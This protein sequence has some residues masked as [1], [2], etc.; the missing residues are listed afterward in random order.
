ML[1]EEVLF[2]TKFLV[3]V[4]ALSGLVSCTDKTANTDP[5]D[6]FK[7]SFASQ[8]KEKVTKAGFWSSWSRDVVKQQVVVSV[9]DGVYHEYK[10]T[11]EDGDDYEL[12][13]RVFRYT[14][15]QDG[16]YE[17][18]LVADECGEIARTA[19]E[20]KKKAQTFKP[21]VDQSS[22][23]TVSGDVVK[24]VSDEEHRKLVADI[25]KNKALDKYDYG[26]NGTVRTMTNWWNK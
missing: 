20:Q 11:S 8:K 22:L 16:S 5:N 24:R 7:G 9:Q 19:A 25:E 6:Q 14:K 10:V 18:I 23:K 4:V 13:E 21:V 1:I 2:M 17:M 15:K 26:C 12:K 3:L